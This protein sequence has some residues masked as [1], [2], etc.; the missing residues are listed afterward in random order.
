MMTSTALRLVLVGCGVVWCGVV[1]CVCYL[2]QWTR[3]EEV[4]RGAG[5]EGV[6]G[7]SSLEDTQHNQI[8]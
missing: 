7:I 1:W 6:E 3:S 2:L 8:F 4:E 5:L